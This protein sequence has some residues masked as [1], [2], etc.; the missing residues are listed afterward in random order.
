MR[1]KNLAEKDKGESSEKNGAMGKK[2]KKKRHASPEQ[3]WKPK[4]LCS[5]QTKQDIDDVIAQIR[6]RRGSSSRAKKRLR[7]CGPSSAPTTP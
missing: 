3:Q 7:G 5:P 1:K 6:A 4:Y 2:K